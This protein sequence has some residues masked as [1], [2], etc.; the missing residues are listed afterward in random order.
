MQ[1]L[2][3]IAHDDRFAPDATLLD[4]I[5]DWIADAQAQGIRRHGKPLR[6]C[7]DAVT[8]RLRDGQ[9]LRSPGPFSNAVEQMCAYELIECADLDAAVQLAARHPMAAAATIEVRP[10]WAELAADAG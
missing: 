1:F 3:I 9:L 6:P 10:V 8:V 2:F 4:R 5:A 7:A